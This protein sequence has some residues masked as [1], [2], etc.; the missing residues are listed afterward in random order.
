MMT[1]SHRKFKKYKI[2]YMK[3][4][5]CVLPHLFYKQQS[6]NAFFN[7]IFHFELGKSIKRQKV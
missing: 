5:Y 4:S 1:G 3:V 6:L 7:G 2:S